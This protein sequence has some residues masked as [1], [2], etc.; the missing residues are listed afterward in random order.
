[1]LN[2]K[3]LRIL[4]EQMFMLFE[5]ILIGLITLALLRYVSQFGSSTL[6]ERAWLS[7]DIKML[8]ETGVSSPQLIVYDYLFPKL[9]TINESDA[10]IK[11]TRTAIEISA[12]EPEKKEEQKTTQ[13]YTYSKFMEF[14]GIEPSANFRIISNGNQISISELDGVNIKHITCER[15][16]QAETTN[17]Q[18]KILGFNENQENKRIIELLTDYFTKG[19][20]K[21]FYEIKDSGKRDL[22]IHIECKQTPEII[23]NMPKIENQKIACLLA[24]NIQEI[25]YDAVWQK[26]DENLIGKADVSVHLIFDCNEKKA[27]SI[28]SAIES[29]YE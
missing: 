1:M 9:E 28:A 20:R 27:V 7:H 22:Y 6:F 29:F 15:Y 25:K 2:K 19:I 5:I 18:K 14:S 10:K 8:I 13:L 23:I 21:E 26:A 12:K 4:S 17:T 3:G 16:K 11:I 24:E